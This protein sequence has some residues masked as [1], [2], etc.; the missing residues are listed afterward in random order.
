MHTNY[1]VLRKAR[2]RGER[3]GHWA[4]PGHD[5]N[6]LK[7]NKGDYLAKVRMFVEIDETLRFAFPRKPKDELIMAKTMVFPRNGEADGINRR[8]NLALVMFLAL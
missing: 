3:G 2:D 8:N 6:M 7:N 4:L 5:A 1:E